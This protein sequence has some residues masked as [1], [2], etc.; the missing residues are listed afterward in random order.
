MG[1]IRLDDR[2]LDNPKILQAGPSGLLL[3]LGGIIYCTRHF[4]DGKI[5]GERIPDLAPLPQDDDPDDLAERLCTIGLWHKNGSGY[6][7]H[8]WHEWNPSVSLLRTRREQ[9]IERIRKYRET[10]PKPEK[11]PK[12]PPKVYVK[13]EVVT[14]GD[15]G[16]V[17]PDSVRA[18]WAGLFPDV[19][20]DRELAHAYEWEPGRR[21]RWVNLNSALFNWLKHASK[22]AYEQR[23]AKEQHR[24][25][26]TAEDVKRRQQQML[27]GLGS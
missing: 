21:T 17:V 2:I 1:S 8:D 4:T 7:V 26:Q 14:R 13:Q 20:I 11:P 25:P 27:E 3:Y 18:R 22:I 23:V 12:A 5:P 15:G 24:K 9:N 16:F 6:Y 19:N 10:H